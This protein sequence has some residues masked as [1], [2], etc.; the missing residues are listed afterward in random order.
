[1]FRWDEIPAIKLFAAEAVE[2]LSFFALVTALSTTIEAACF[3]FSG[4]ESVDF[5]TSVISPI[6]L[7]GA[8]ELSGRKSEKVKVIQVEERKGRWKM[9]GLGERLFY[10]RDSLKG[11]SGDKERTQFKVPKNQVN[12]GK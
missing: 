10:F 1:L 5:A 3:A 2:P 11:R 9:I 4:I 6:A 8:E 12:L 7:S